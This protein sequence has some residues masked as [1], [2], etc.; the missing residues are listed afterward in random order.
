M[1]MPIIYDCDNTMGLPRKEIDG[2]VS[3]FYL[4]DLLPAVY[5]SHPELFDEKLVVVRSTVS[6]L[7][8]GTLVIADDREG[9]RINMPARILDVGQF[10]AV[11]FAAWQ[12][13]C[14]CS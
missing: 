11:L 13:R 12:H 6:D 1:S 4:W 7:E 3:V 14:S 5:I 8:T 2:G 9:A 10:M